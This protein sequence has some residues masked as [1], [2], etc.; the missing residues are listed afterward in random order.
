MDLAEDGQRNF[1]PDPCS[2]L[3]VAGADARVLDLLDA[4]KIPYLIGLP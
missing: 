1:C 4:N 3:I 2:R